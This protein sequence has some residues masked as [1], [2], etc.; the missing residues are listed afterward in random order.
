MRPHGPV[1]LGLLALLVGCGDSSPGARNAKDGGKPK[2]PYD[3]YVDYYADGEIVFLDDCPSNAELDEGLTDLV[4]VDK[5]G[6]EHRVAD[7]AKGRH[8]VLIMTR[9]N[10]TPI[11]P[12]CSTQ[13]ANYIRQYA[14]FEKRGAEVLL[15]YP[16]ELDR[17]KAKL[18]P[19]LDDVRT[20]LEDPQ[21]KVP[22]PVLFDVELQAVD[23]LG[24]RKDLSKPATYVVDR[25]GHVRYAYVG[26]DLADRPSVKA[27][28]D[29]LDELGGSKADA[30]ADDDAPVRSAD[31]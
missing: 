8:I 14:D 22:F 2:D 7:F 19:F 11:C 21:R 1:L 6:R 17:H 15:A 28:L 16:V 12:F 30:A 5:L 27:I 25:D 9:G 29:E 31:R 3:A 18:R 20:R 24:I 23:K 4:F 26:K 13:T 10:T